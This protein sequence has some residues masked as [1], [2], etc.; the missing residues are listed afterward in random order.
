MAEI[1]ESPSWWRGFFH[2]VMGE[3]LQQRGFLRSALN[4]LSW[5]TTVQLAGTL[6]QTSAL[7]EELLDQAHDDIRII[8]G[9]ISKGPAAFPASAERRLPEPDRRCDV[10]GARYSSVGSVCA[11]CGTL[12]ADGAANCEM[13]GYGII[14]WREMIFCPVCRS[15]FFK[16][17]QG[18]PVQYHVM[19]R[20]PGGRFSVLWPYAN[21]GRETLY[22][23]ADTGR[24]EWTQPR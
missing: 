23:Y 19:P 7:P 12:H 4:H 9:I 24:N 3:T 15:G 5:C 20:T 2:L 16:S 17:V 22:R 8:Q 10:C 13:C 14:S 18:R 6:E 11:L 21:P 1:A